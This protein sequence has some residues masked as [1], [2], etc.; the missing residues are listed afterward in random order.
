MPSIRTFVLAA[1][2]LGGL[3]GCFD[4][5]EPKVAAPPPAQVKPPPKPEGPDGPQHRKAA[6]AAAI[7]FAKPKYKTEL[8]YDGAHAD[9]VRPT[10]ATATVQPPPPMY[11]GTAEVKH[12]PPATSP[13]LSSTGYWRVYIHPIKKKKVESIDPTSLTADQMGMLS[14]ATHSDVLFRCFVVAEGKKVHE[15]EAPRVPRIAMPAGMVPVGPPAPPET[16]PEA[17]SP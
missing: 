14:D 7:E 1:V 16:P 17:S 2:L 5:D 13:S 3:A 15:D 6:I 10:A 11:A 9:Y 12:A 8:D 4:S